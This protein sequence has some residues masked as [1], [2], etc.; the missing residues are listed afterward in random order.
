MQ[1]SRLNYFTG[2]GNSKDATV[3]A[4]HSYFKINERI[5]FGLTVN[6]EHIPSLSEAG[7]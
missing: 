6:Q 5:N 4:R 2:V 7:M 3:I 1:S